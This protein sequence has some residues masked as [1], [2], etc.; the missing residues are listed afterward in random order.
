M[1]S[2]RSQALQY[3]VREPYVHDGHTLHMQR[4]L[5]PEGADLYILSKMRSGRL[6]LD[7]PDRAYHLK[8]GDRI[9]LCRSEEPLTV[10]GM[11]RR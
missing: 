1:L 11:R 7:G 3:V 4:G 9:R 8:L 6:F 2:L 10:L 5:V